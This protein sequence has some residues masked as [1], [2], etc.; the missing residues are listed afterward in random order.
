MNLRPGS[1]RRFPATD[2]N[3]RGHRSMISVRRRHT[4]VFLSAC[5]TFVLFCIASTAAQEKAIKFDAATVSGL[6][7]RNIGSAAMS[8]LIDDVDAIEKDGRITVFVGS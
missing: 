1:R 7:A 8:G 5:L 4:S 2:L 3:Q 6:P